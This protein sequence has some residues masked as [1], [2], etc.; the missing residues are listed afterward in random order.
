MKEIQ[1]F[2]QDTKC[3]K[4]SC[5]SADSKFIEGKK[6]SY[7]TEDFKDGEILEPDHIRRKCLRCEYKWYEKCADA[8]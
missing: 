1:E 5:D 6:Y 7:V 2:N 3:L 4:C 8:K